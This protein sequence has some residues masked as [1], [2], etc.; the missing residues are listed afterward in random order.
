MFKLIIINISGVRE[1]KLYEEAIQSN[2]HVSLYYIKMLALGPAQVGKTTFIHRLLGKMQWDMD[3]APTNTQP[4]CSTGQCELKE[5]FIEYNSNTLT[6]SSCEQTWHTFEEESELKKE[7]MVF[8]SL[9]N[10]QAVEKQ[11]SNTE[12][13]GQTQGLSHTGDES[14]TSPEKAIIHL[15]TSHNE[16]V[17][18]KSYDSKAVHSQTV[19]TP[20]AR[21]EPLSEVSKI[22]T[23]TSSSKFKAAQ[24]EF[25][26]L[27]C[28]I[29]AIDNELNSVRI[30]INV[31][32]IGGQPAFLEMLPSLTIGP[33][34]Y[35]VFMNALHGLQTEYATKFKSHNDMQARVC[36]NYAYTAEEVIFTA[37]SSIACLGHTD[38]EIE[39]YVS[40]SPNS[41]T[42]NSLALLVAT[43]MDQIDPN[44]FSKTEQQ[45]NEML[46]ETCFHT[47]GL[48]EYSKL[49]KG[50]VLH[51]INNK[52]GGKAEVDEFREKIRNLIEKRFHEYRIPACWL[53]LSICLR[54]FARF[55]QE[56]V[57][58]LDVCLKIGKY[59]GI[60][61]EMVRAALK[62]LHRYI[63]L[64]LYFPENEKLKDR[65]ICNPQA[66]FSTIN[67][68]IFNVYDPDKRNMPGV[69]CERFLLTGCFC[70][71][72]I[73]VDRKDLV[74][75]NYLT[76][77]LMHLNIVAPVGVNIT[78]N[79]HEYFLPAV[80]QTAKIDELKIIPK[81][82]NEEQDPE[83]LCV[84]FKTGY[85][86]LGFVCALAANLMRTN[87]GSLT[88]LSKMQNHMIYKNKFTF[89]FRG[90]Y[91]IIL[92]SW[93]KYSEFRVV[94]ALG[95]PSNEDFDSRNC[96]PQI[97]DMLTQ[98]INLVIDGMRQSSLFQMSSHYDFA[99]KCSNH[100]SNQDLGHEALAVITSDCSKEMTCTKCKTVT[101]LTSQMSVWFGKVSFGIL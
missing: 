19:S 13:Y 7:L 53:S 30:I 52:S 43:F 55:K 98:S 31:A 77:L 9:L 21:I 67:E 32:D 90:R 36:E 18:E 54:N 76:D 80:L 51:Q 35:L 86:P 40:T 50:Q 66:I 60:R 25:Y 17:S 101:L 4:Q 83:P 16:A 95:S 8:S 88:L 56:S 45:L 58:P 37:L 47:N 69:E 99:F 89:R 97:K 2:M 6:F 100:S 85:L 57:L 1:I 11:S 81:E 10:E 84:R 68:L 78:T 74:P 59:F 24:D 20:M 46:Q 41:R 96:C 65:V 91:D 94:R 29:K 44:I 73:K 93:P 71:A 39:K 38:K 75:I 87:S 26:K 82:T 64:I 22:I 92:I 70:P 63:G 62:F 33:A 61:E 79:S 48:V 5:A 49:L 3:T 27:N 14:G 15:D 28:F 72:R 34:M 12:P 42:I 23:E